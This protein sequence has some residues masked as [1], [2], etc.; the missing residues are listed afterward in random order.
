MINLGDKVKDVVTGF[1]GV[2]V[3]K[4][5]YLN[6]CRRYEIKPDKLKDGKTIDSE[7]IDIQQLKVVEEN[8]FSKQKNTGSG[9]SGNTPSVRMPKF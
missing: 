4:I 8:I 1:E 2:A 5:E 3:A 7:W 6:G 9:G